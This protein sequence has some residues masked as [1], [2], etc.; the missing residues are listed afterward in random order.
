MARSFLCSLA[1]VS[2]AWRYLT[3][4]EGD[5]VQTGEQLSLVLMD[6]LHLNVKH[7]VGMDN[8]A[9]VLLQVR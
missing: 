2:V 1:A 7:G 4:V 8:Q 5:G 3:I 9:V 6:S